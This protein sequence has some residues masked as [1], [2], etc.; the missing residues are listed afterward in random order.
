MAET[1]NIYE[2]KTHLSALVEKAAAGEEIIIAKA[3]KP[4]AKLVP[5]EPKV[6][7]P[8]K[9][10]QNVLGITYIAP[11]FDAPLPDDILEDFYGPI[12]PKR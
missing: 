7:A 8:R 6:Q 5:L 11:D 2:A 12:E 4:M 10:G 3:G 1:L 9:F